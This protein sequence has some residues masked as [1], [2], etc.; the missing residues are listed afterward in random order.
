MDCCGGRS[1]KRRG[2]REGDRDPFQIV[3]CFAL[4]CRQ[5]SSSLSPLFRNGAVFCCYNLYNIIIAA[6]VAVLLLRLCAGLPDNKMRTGMRERE[7]DRIR[8]LL[9]L[10]LYFGRDERRV[11]QE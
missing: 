4:L 1:R 6:V 8:R 10:L 3:I 9:L 2:Q 11:E 5:Q 7:R